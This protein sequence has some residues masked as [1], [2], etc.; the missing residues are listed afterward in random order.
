[1]TT[2]TTL[3]KIDTG[4]LT[5]YGSE[6]ELQIFMERAAAIFQI[7]AED[8]ERPA[9]QA[10]LLKATQNC[11]RYGYLPGIHVHMI[12]FNVNVD[13]PHPQNPKVTVKVKERVYAP[14]MGE[15]AWKDS[16]DRIAKDQRFTYVVQTKAMSADEV[17]AA[18]S[19]IPGQEYHPNDAGCK[20]RVLR[21]DHAELYKLVGEKYDPEWVMGFW[22]QKKDQWG[23]PDTIPNGR[24]PADVAMRRATKAA[25]M[26]VFH[27]VPIDEY[28]DSMRF[29]RMAA[30]VETETAPAA[31]AIPQGVLH[32]RSSYTVDDD[33]EMWAED[34]ESARQHLIAEERAKMVDEP[35][36]TISTLDDVEELDFNELTS[37]PPQPPSA[38]GPCPACHA[39]AGKPHAS[40][41]TAVAADKP[42][43]PAVQDAPPTGANAEFD[44]LPGHGKNGH[45][46][47]VT[48]HQKKRIA[49]LVVELYGPDWAAD[50]NEAKMSNWASDNTA[51]TFATLSKSEAQTLLDLLVRRSTAKKQKETA[52]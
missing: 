49:E 12:P 43:P 31:S 8:L 13:K 32:T 34:W 24:T 29:R 2:S 18:T 3:T 9:V 35:G 33:G 4:V 19:L 20:A 37:T 15:K 5:R 25:L 39:P 28:E 46:P 11:L 30:Y 10:S 44:R 23:N 45:V 1:M 41:C 27:L 42:T 17:K 40:T 6:Q 14:D 47:S 51:E 22:R 52:Q 21:S 7:P 38:D 16:A 26:A 48:D 50:N 36:P